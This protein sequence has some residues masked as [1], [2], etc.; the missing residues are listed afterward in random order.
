MNVLFTNL[1]VYTISKVSNLV[2]LA[3]VWHVP[4]SVKAVV[5]VTSVRNIYRFDYSNGS[6]L[7]LYLYFVAYT[8]DD[9]LCL[10]SIDEACHCFQ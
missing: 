6:Y 2:V 7:E 9:V 8:W 5:L 4:F 1:E 10:D 3:D